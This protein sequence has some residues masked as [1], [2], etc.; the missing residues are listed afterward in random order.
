LK[1]ISAPERTRLGAQLQQFY[2]ESKFAK[3]LVQVEACL[4]KDGEG[5]FIADQE[6]SDVVHDQLAY[7]AERMLKM[8]KQKQQEIK[9]FLGWLG[10]LR[11]K[12]RQ[13]DKLI[14]QVVY[15][16]YA[17]TEEEIGIVEG[18]ANENA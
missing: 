6:K 11:E 9:G 1:A 7:L 15:R 17:L 2:A 18:K 3:I 14:D 13:K 8:N 10:P 4:P 5:N 16:L 12:I